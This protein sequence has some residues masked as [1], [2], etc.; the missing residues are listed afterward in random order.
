MDPN[1]EFRSLHSRGGFGHSGRIR[2][3]A[4]GKWLKPYPRFG[5]F[6]KAAAP[7]ALQGGPPDLA[8]RRSGPNPD[9]RF[10]V[11]SLNCEAHGSKARLK[12]KKPDS[13]FNP[14]RRAR[15]KKPLLAN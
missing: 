2:A 5:G 3:A 9:S 14:L 6:W 10:R 11:P 13:R 7:L 4:G 1:R 8:V 12:A 15:C